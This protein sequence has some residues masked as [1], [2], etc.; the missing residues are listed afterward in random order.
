MTV[1]ALPLDPPLQCT[2]ATPVSIRGI[3]VHAGESVFLELLPAEVDSGVVFERS[4][5]PAGRGRIAA[6][7]R[8]VTDTRLCTVIANDSGATVSTLEH[9]M[10]ALAA[11][12][13]DNVLVRLDG[14]EV[15]IL[16]GSA[17][18]WMELIRGAG[19]VPQPVRRRQLRILRPVRIED[20]EKWA[21]LL[22]DRASRYSIGIEFSDPLIG[23]QGFDFT[24][25]TEGFR[26]EIA[27]A[28]TFGFAR[29]VSAMQAAGRALGGSLDNAVVVEDG[30]VLNPGGLRFRDEFVRH[31]LL[32]CIGDLY[33][34]GGPIQGHLVASRPGHA[35]NV[36][37]LRALFATE[38]AWC[39]GGRTE[40][41]CPELAAAA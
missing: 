38:G 6:S 1:S 26:R 29:E 25:S 30:K 39:W 36:D 2:V 17:A 19:V 41:G 3:G 31:K 21:M 20:G 22:P 13:I 5:L 9:L 10:A 8:N 27:P 7:W 11:C 32:D 37:L 18:Q 24:L 23:R 12:G 4:D 40:A 33:L 28:R 35:L 14:P 34:A 15:P 16:D